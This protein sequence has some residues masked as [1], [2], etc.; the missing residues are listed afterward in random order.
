MTS[1]DEPIDCQWLATTIGAAPIA[2]GDH[3]ARRAIVHL[4][5]ETAMRVAVDW[6]VEGRSAAER[7]RSVLW[8]LRPAAPRSRCVEIYRTDPD[9]Q[10]RHLAV[11]LLG[12]VDLWLLDEF[13]ADA[14]HSSRTWGIGVLDQLLFRG[15]SPRSLKVAANGARPG[16]SRQHR[17]LGP[18]RRPSTG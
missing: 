5:G 10:R 6:Y 2:G 13:L 15:D 7:A 9:P 1:H 3:I 8:L 4:L 12:V 16:E 17:A 11:E 14:D 18:R